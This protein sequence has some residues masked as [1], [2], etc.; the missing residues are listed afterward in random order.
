MRAL[1]VA[2]CIATSPAIAACGATLTQIEQ[3]V[4]TY[5]DLVVS[6]LKAGKTDTQIVDDILAQMGAGATVIAATNVFLNIANML[7]SSGL[8]ASSNPEL[9]ANTQAMAAQSVDALAAKVT[10]AHALRIDKGKQ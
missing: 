6:D 9:V 4:K 1:I 8:L 5:T 7:L 10:T 2:V 3:G